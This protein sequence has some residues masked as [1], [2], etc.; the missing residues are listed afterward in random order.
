MLSMAVPGPAQGWCGTG[1]RWVWL[2]GI[3]G[4]PRGEHSEPGFLSFADHGEKNSILMNQEVLTLQEMLNSL[5]FKRKVGWWRVLI[6]HFACLSFPKS[7]PTEN[8]QG[9]SFYQFH[10]HWMKIRWCFQKL[11]SLTESAWVAILHPTPLACETLPEVSL[12]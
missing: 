7:H 10:L 1:L 12:T 2:W 5:D 6:G 9:L 4:L 8:N 3:K 11:S